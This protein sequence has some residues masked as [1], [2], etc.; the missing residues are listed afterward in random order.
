MV[1]GS[2]GDV[3]RAARLKAGLTQHEVACRAGISVRTVR[4]IERGHVKKPRQDS[5]EQI[6]EV[7][8][9]DLPGAR[10][11]SP[12]RQAESARSGPACEIRVL[13]PLTVRRAGEPVAMPLKQRVLLG[14][15]SIQPNRVVS[16]HEIADVLWNGEAPASAAELVHTYVARLRRITEPRGGRDH[17]IATVRGGYHFTAG[18]ARLDLLR[19][20]E[21]SDRAAESAA[22][23]PEAALDLFSRALQHWQGPV[24]EDLPVLRQH[25]AAVAIAQRRADVAIT[26]A[27][28][29]LRLNRPA[30]A[31]EHLMAAAHE[32]PLHEGLQARIMLALAGSGRKATALQLFVDLRKQLRRELGVEPSEE[33]WEARRRI[34]VPPGPGE[35]A[36]EPVTERAGPARG[37]PGGTA[38]VRAPGD[39]PELHPPLA[40]R[41]RPWAVAL[42][43]Q[44]PP[45]VRPFVGRQ[46]QLAELDALLAHQRKEYSSM[47]IA[48][49]HGPA[50]I[51]KTALALHWSHREHDEFPDGQ[52]YADLRGAAR[53]SAAP[54]R[55]LDVLVRFLRS[56]GVADGGIPDSLE[57]ASALF[58]TLLA[59]RHVLVLLDDAADTEQVRW[60]LPGTPGNT[61]VVTSRGPLLDLV[62]R[63]GAKPL[64]LDA[65]SP[66]EA[67]E[68]LGA[69]LGDRRTAA[70]PEATAELAALCGHHP[71]QLRI[72]AARLAAAPQV[73]I[74]ACLRDHA[75]AGLRPRPR[76]P[77]PEA[78][79]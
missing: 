16:H 34:L 41:S 1:G 43:A 26:F 50:E 4:H 62:A 13:G 33:M 7:L 64:A 39:L 22:A 31:L 35:P 28:L 74:R 8:G 53:P 67:C 24:L 20:G 32:E 51:G 77:R 47:A 14:L 15:L 21:L 49:I 72:A 19:F 45:A 63:D 71:L 6:A 37:R 54:A 48:A 10:P 75:S 12:D 66:E 69:Y 25:P 68:L 46:R 2:W 42:P 55:P 38:A 60:L 56:L 29:A 18:A 3:L 44:L 76:P 73:S 70:E 17:L 23:D 61:V 40:A 65:L 58:R 79:G 36:D 59:G 5:L 9:V 27:D 57:E 30:C 52:L 11:D 78:G